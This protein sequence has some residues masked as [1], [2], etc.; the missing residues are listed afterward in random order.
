MAPAG[1]QWTKVISHA[2]QGASWGAAGEEA[3]A[4]EMGRHPVLTG[5]DLGCHPNLIPTA[6]VCVYSDH[7]YKFFFFSF[8]FLF[9]LILIPVR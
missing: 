2:Y 5:L 3:Q 9:S 1:W 4:M 7:F 8:L 6:N